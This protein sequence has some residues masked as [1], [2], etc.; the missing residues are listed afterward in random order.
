[1]LA[2]F[3]VAVDGVTDPGSGFGFYLAD[4][5][6]VFNEPL[7]GAIVLKKTGLAPGVHIVEL[8]WSRSAALAL[9]ALVIRPLTTIDEHASLLVV[10]SS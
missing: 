1:M 5:S 8:R 6:N 2:H 10:T 4:N 9:A 7:S 3:E